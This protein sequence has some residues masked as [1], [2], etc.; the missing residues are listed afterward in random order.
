MTSLHNADAGR[1]L[2]RENG[3]LGS[4][5][6]Q[7]FT[8]SQVVV[9]PSEV[10]I[11]PYRNTALPSLKKNQPK[12][13]DQTSQK[14]KIWPN[15]FQSLETSGCPILSR[16]SQGATAQKQDFFFYHNI[17]QI[18][19]NEHCTGKKTVMVDTGG[20]EGALETD[21]HYCVKRRLGMIKDLDIGA[22]C[23][24]LRVQ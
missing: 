15:T 24:P 21:Q 20:R 9:N 10:I 14:G 3:L 8:Y 16:T 2:P 19:M 13:K 12:P 11:Y 22:T 4:S 18:L 1:I 7:A 17:R 23:G 5:L 6:L